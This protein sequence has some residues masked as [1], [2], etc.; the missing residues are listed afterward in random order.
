[1]PLT[2]GSLL[3]WRVK[4][5]F[6]VPSLV[7]SKDRIDPVVPSWDASGL[8]AQAELQGPPSGF[9]FMKLR[10]AKKGRTVPAT[11]VIRDSEGEKTLRQRGARWLAG[12]AV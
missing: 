10:Q 7:T 12:A 6:T 5:M 4:L 11:I 2:C 8:Y 9:A 1:M 3:P